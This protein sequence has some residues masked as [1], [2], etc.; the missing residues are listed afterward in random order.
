MSR[1]YPI[2]TALGQV[3]SD[4]G[5]MVLMS[6]VLLRFGTPPCRVSLSSHATQF[7]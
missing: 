1:D 5:V 7:D 4:S 3:G 6:S 2:T